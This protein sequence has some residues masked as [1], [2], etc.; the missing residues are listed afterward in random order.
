[1]NVFP[2]EKRQLHKIKIVVFWIWHVWYH[3]A[4]FVTHYVS[5]HMG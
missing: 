1:M 3:D 5:S 4:Y 2:K